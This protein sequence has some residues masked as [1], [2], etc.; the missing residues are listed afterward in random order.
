[1]RQIRTFRKVGK[2][3]GKVGGKAGDVLDKLDLS[4]SLG[5]SLVF[6]FLSNPFRAGS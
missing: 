6:Q 4:L 1:M 3:G 5:T 2:V